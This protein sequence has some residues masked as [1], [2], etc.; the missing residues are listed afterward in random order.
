MLGCW[1]V[2]AHQCRIASFPYCPDAAYFYDPPANERFGAWSQMARIY[3]ADCGDPSQKQ[4]AQGT[5]SRGKTRMSQRIK[6]V[7]AKTDESGNTLIEARQGIRGNRVG[8][9]VVSRGRI[10][11]SRRSVGRQCF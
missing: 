2:G 9:S 10:W 8:A 5:T 11:N 3:A 7:A 1:N 4:S 6:H